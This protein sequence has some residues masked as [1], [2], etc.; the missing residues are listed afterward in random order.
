MRTPSPFVILSI[1]FMFKILVFLLFLEKNRL[2]S[3]SKK[4]WHTEPR[5]VKTDGRTKPWLDLPKSPFLSLFR[6]FLPAVAGKCWKPSPEPSPTLIPASKF[7][8]PENPFFLS[9]RQVR[10]QT[11]GIVTR[12]RALRRHT[13]RFVGFGGD[14]LSRRRNPRKRRT[15]ADVGDQCNN[16]GIYGDCNL[17][18][19]RMQQHRTEE[20]SP[21]QS[22]NVAI[23]IR[24]DHLRQAPQMLPGWF[25]QRILLHRIQLHRRYLPTKHPPVFF[26]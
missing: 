16:A 4:G 5:S 17:D 7:V 10:K 24:R 19:A 15:R 1:F 3:S 26:L 13:G 6:R 20:C 8:L 18:S 2:K 21:A 22:Y 14:T 23:F 25:R 11:H 12:T 9:K